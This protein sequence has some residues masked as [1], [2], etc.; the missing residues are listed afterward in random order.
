M[1]HLLDLATVW[2]TRPCKYSF[3]YGSM[4]WN[5]NAE[6]SLIMGLMNL[7][8]THSWGFFVTILWL[9]GRVLESSYWRF[10]LV[11]FWYYL[12]KTE[13]VPFLS[14]LWDIVLPVL[15]FQANVCR[16][17]KA[18]FNLIAGKNIRKY[19]I[20]LQITDLENISTAF[21]YV[22]SNMMIVL[23]LLHSSFV[24]SRSTVCN[25]TL[26]Y[27]STSQYENKD[28]TECRVFE[29][30]FIKSRYTELFCSKIYR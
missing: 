1:W 12:V 11:V 29:E 18:W 6:H 8:V 21:N 3:K 4:N 24:Y 28:M 20:T 2:V 25:I 5:I 15:F 27:S 22:W 13:Q 14:L 9:T 19:K 23:F 10:V 26:I 16:I 30:T 17:S 7:S